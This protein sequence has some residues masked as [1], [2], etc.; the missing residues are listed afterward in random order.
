[1]P[2][3]LVTYNVKDL[4]DVPT[5]SSRVNLDAKLA[6]LAGVLGRANADVVALQ[7]V[8]SGKIVRELTS[9]V[10]ALRYGEPIVGTADARGIRCAIVSR[11]PVL[12]S[13]VHTADHLPFPA[14]VAGDPPPF[15][16]RIPLRRGIVRARVDAGPLG[17]VDVLVAHFKSNRPLALREAAGDMREMPLVT[18]R[19]YAEAHLRSLVWRSAEA[20]FVRGLV[21][22][23]LADDA[24]GADRAARSADAPSGDRRHVIVAGDLNDHPTSAVVRVVT[25]GG[26][27]A[28][29]PCADVVPEAARFSILRYGEPQQ[30]DHVLVTRLLR[31]RLTAARFLNEGLRDHS[32]LGID[33]P[34]HPDSDHAP[35]LVSFA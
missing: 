19:D 28:L 9:L 1:M 20:L 18:A 14:F 33:A 21:D 8:G 34:P 4:F 7:E 35:L 24:P 17:A 12:E 23:L 11:L 25:G 5:G 30:I 26:P 15:G 10:P 31:E 32:D 29:R 6:H 22:G 13:Q 27:L 3:S 2:F 16:T